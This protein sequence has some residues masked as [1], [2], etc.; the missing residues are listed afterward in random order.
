VPGHTAGHT[1]GHRRRA[2]R[3]ED[4]LGLSADEALHSQ[5]LLAMALPMDFMSCGTANEIA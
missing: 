3:S 2:Y 1:W 5:M 4:S